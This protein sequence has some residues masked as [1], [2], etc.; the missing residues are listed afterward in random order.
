M[1]NLSELP[2]VGLLVLDP[3]PAFLGRHDS[4]HQGSVR[5]MLDPLLELAEQYKIAVVG[6]MHMNKS[7]K[8]KNP[9]HRAI[10][11]LAYTALARTIHLVDYHTRWRGG[12]RPES[13]A[14]MPR[15]VIPLKSNLAPIAHAT[16]FDITERGSIH[17]HETAVLDHPLLSLPEPS[18]DPVPQSELDFACEFLMVT[19]A[20]GPLVSAELRKLALAEG[21]SKRTYERA[22][23][24]LWIRPYHEPGTNIWRARLPGDS[25]DADAV[26]QGI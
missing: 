26:A 6:I 18:A 19:L 9:L 8:S 23:W 17:W 12:R 14:R 1:M 11:S 22:R 20:D 13:L 15:L 25:L 16:A 3:L 24:D 4:Y 7:A 2:N 21:I 5:S 10:G